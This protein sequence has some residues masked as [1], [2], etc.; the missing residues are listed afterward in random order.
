MNR[1]VFFTVNF[2]WDRVYVDYW[3]TSFKLLER[4]SMLRFIR[5]WLNNFV[6]KESIFQKI[7][8]VLKSPIKLIY[9]F[10]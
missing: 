9:N 1:D 4:D 10:S 5:N 3:V 7:S 2:K 8:S 6:F